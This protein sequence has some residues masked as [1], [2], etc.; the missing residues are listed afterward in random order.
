[1]ADDEEDPDGPDSWLVTYADAITLLMAFFVVLISFSKIDLVTYE[2]VKSGINENV[3]GS[4]SSDRPLYQV[5][6]AVDSI[7]LDSTDVDESVVQVGFDNEG[8]VVDFASGSF[9]RAGS[10]ELTPIA[11]EFLNR[12]RRELQT[13]PFDLF[14]LD[15]EGHTDDS[16]INSESFPSN[17]EL[18][19]SRAATVVRFYVDAGMEPTRLKA[20]GFADTVPKFPNRDV[21]GNPIPGN[22]AKNRRVTIRIHP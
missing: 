7:V 14:R 18:S 5:Y 6:N 15:V 4:S 19:A 17:W 9:F 21:V 16:P 12:V 11:R 22:Q 1:M 8:V 10:T 3:S 20:T 13:P 2:A